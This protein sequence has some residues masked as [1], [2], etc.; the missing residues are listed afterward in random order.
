MSGFVS[1]IPSCEGLKNAGPK[2]ACGSS[3]QETYHAVDFCPELTLRGHKFS[4][5][6]AHPYTLQVQ[7]AGVKH[8][9]LESN[10]DEKLGQI[11]AEINSLV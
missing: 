7:L 1:P 11:L 5:E 10:L 6:I 8:P 9:Y 2:Y 3:Q 4:M